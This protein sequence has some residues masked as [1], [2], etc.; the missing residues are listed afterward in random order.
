MH[1]H[2]HINTLIYLCIY[3]CNH[4]RGFIIILKKSFSVSKAPF[5][6]LFLGHPWVG[7][8]RSRYR[9]NKYVGQGLQV[10]RQAPKNRFSYMTWRKT[11][12]CQPPASRGSATTPCLSSLRRNIS[13]ST[14]S[15]ILAHRWRERDLHFTRSTYL[16]FFIESMTSRRNS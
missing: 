5:L 3:K 11:G 2:A 12:T 8:M 1:I 9:K 10:D 7:V 4:K 16:L 15:L 6:C 13:T 14:T